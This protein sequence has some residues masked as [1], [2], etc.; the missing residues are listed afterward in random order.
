[1]STRKKILVAVE[2]ALFA[3]FVALLLVPTPIDPAGW[4][5][6]SG[7]ELTGVLDVGDEGLKGCTLLAADAVD[8]PED[9]AVDG[10]GHIW[11]GTLD[12]RIVRAD[13]HGD[14]VET[15]AETGGRPLGLAF[16]DGGADGTRRLIVADGDRGLLAVTEDGALEVLA[17]GHEGERFR[18][19]DDI[20]VAPDGRFYF[21]DASSRWGYGSHLYD[22]LE[23]RP[24]GSLLRYDPATGSTERLLDGLYFANGIAVAEDGSFVLV[25]ETYRYR[26]TRYWLAGDRAGESEILIDNLPGFPDGISRGPRGTFWIALFTIRNPL[27]DRLHPRPFL[28]ARLAALPGFLWPKPQRYG[29]VL[30]I[31][32][33]GRVLRSLHDSSGRT[34]PQVT[35]VEEVDGALYLGNLDHRGIARCPLEL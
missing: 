7:P 18:F 6:P 3:A 19:A 12:G 20:D 31:D 27:M 4:Q 14:R 1:M 33:D 30:E 9:V 24:W 21:S 29:L 23:A 17:E 16:D 15:V 25:N 2:V 10:A 5:P 28:K 8:G 26:V 22:L 11:A 34:V 32:G 35:S 13:A